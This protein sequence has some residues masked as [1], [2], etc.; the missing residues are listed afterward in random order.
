MVK[1]RICSKKLKIISPSHLRTHNI[2]TKEYRELYPNAPMVGEAYTH[3]SKYWDG[4]DN[5]M[6][7][8]PS[9][10]KGKDVRS[11]EGK[12]RTTEGWRKW[13]EENPSVNRGENNPNYKGG[14]LLRECPICG[15]GFLV[16][17]SL[18]ERKKTCSKECDRKH[19][20]IKMKG[21]KMPI[22]GRQK[23]SNLRMGEKNPAWRGGTSFEPYPPK[24]NSKLKEFCIKSK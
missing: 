20:T 9:S 22:E 18:K 1:C 19:R 2:T 5:P 23:L 6:Y 21:W 15:G 24:F 17:P 13:F 4:E 11:P 3:L 7:G 10:N 16:K 12:Q 8:K 14:P